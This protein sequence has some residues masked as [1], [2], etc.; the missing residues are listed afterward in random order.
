MCALSGLT[1]A[2]VRLGH[3]VLLIYSVVVVQN[4]L[5][6]LLYAGLGRSGNIE[7]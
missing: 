4:I 2:P 1:R 3:A 6:L 7:S 5:D